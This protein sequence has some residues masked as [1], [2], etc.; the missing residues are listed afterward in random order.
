MRKYQNLAAPDDQNTWFNVDGFWPNPSGSYETIQFLDSGT[1]ATA[2]G[3]GDPIYAWCAKTLSGRREYVLTSALIWEYSAGA[4]TDRTGGVTIGSSPYAVQNGDV[5][6]M[7][8]GAANPTV[9]STG[10]NFS[11]LAGAPQAEIVLPVAGALLYLNTSVSAD[12]WATSDVF[13]YTNYTTGEAASGRL[14]QTPGA[15][16]AGVSFGNYAIVFK[17]DAIYKISYVGGVV[18]WTTEVLYRGI[19]A[20][21]KYAA[22][23]GNGRILFA[24]YA[25][26]Y[27]TTYYYLFDGVSE[28]RRVNPL[29]TVTDGYG[30]SAITFN[31]QLQLFTIRGL[32]TGVTVL[33]VTTYSSTAYYYSLAADAWGKYTNVTATYTRKPLFGE[34]SALSEQSS[35]H[36]L[37]GKSAADTLK[38][39][40]P[41][42]TADGS[43]SLNLPLMGSAQRKISL[44]KV[45]PQY[46]RR[47]S[48]TSAAVVTMTA[49]FY[50]ERG[51]SRLGAR[52][53][54]ASLTRSAVAESTSPQRCFDTTGSDYF[55][56]IALNWTNAFVELDDV[57]IEA[58]SGGR[59]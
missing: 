38:R 36:V 57:V 30:L 4:Y 53:G 54:A 21:S 41:S 22:C 23:A 50:P 32:E 18:K 13:D 26:S 3:T 35:T 11:A 49:V 45:I 47:D 31:P 12:G 9:K 6:V 29:T 27:F 17:A 15:I 42:R 7:A 10:G 52:G 33:G 56:D 1:A 5:T 51:L 44:T 16:T 28:P 19:G 58:N 25:D 14:L 34:F 8:M 37:Y 2:T 40:A 20:T 43:C 46:R 55:V 24:G 48:L 59:S 39:F